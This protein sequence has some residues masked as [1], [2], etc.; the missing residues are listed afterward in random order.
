MH[1]GVVVKFETRISS[2]SCASI[3]LEIPTSHNVE[4]IWS[5][6]KKVIEKYT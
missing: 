3:L 2:E 6:R 1:I 5:L 4:Q